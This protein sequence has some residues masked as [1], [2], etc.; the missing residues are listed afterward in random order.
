M[1]LIQACRMDVGMPQP[2]SRCRNDGAAAIQ[3][4]RTAIK[5]SDR[6]LLGTNGPM[7]LRPSQH[8]A[9]TSPSEIGRADEANLA[10]HPAGIAASSF[11]TVFGAPPRQESHRGPSTRVAFGKW[12]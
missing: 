2:K 8:P 4:F 10:P 12:R 1:E 3:A 7:S 5:D 9:C 6:E 11:S